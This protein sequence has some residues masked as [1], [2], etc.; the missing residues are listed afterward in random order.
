MFFL[1]KN[2]QGITVFL[3][4]SIDVLHTRLTIARTQR[5]L[6][7]GK[8]DEELRTYISETLSHRLPFYS[9]ANHT[10]C[11]DHLEN[12]RQVGESVARFKQE[13]L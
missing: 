8:N 6:V 4:A 7:A 10:F 1:L 9:R 3:E 2:Q 5:P 13:I 12:I 11:A